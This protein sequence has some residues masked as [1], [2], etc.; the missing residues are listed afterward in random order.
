LVL[1]STRSNAQFSIVG[2][3]ELRAALGPDLDYYSEFMDLSM[4][5]EAVSRAFHEFLR[6]KYETI[7]FDLIIALQDRAIDFVRARRDT[8]FRET[9]L[10]FL[11][12]NSAVGRLENET[13]VVHERNFDAT[14]AFIRQ[15]Q[16][17]VQH[18]FVVTGA[19]EVDREY[20]EALRRQLQASGDGLNIVYL[21]GL[22]AAELEDRLSRLPERSAV[23]YVFV[24]EDAAGQK[25]HPLTYA[26]TVSAMA[27]APTYSW[28]DS[29]IDHGIVGGSL[30]RQRLAVQR[31]GQLAARVLRGEPIDTIPV[32]ALSLNAN[33]ADWRQLRRWRID[34]SRV[35]AGSLIRFRNPT[36][37]DQY[38]AYILA[39]L[40]LLVAETALIAGL[41]IHRQRRRRV[42]EV[43]RGVNSE[44]R[45]SHERNR[46]LGA[47]LLKAQET[48]RAQIA[49]E[50]HDDI[51]QRMLLL[52]I[53]LDS[54]SRATAPQAPAREALRL[55][56][57]LA[58]SLHELSHRLYPA[59][60]RLIGLVSALDHLCA[61][62]S[63]A[64]ATVSFVHR[65]VPP[66]L[67]PE[68]MLCVFRVV[69]EALHN[70]FKYS[71]A[72]DL[73]V[74]LSGGSSGLT[75]VVTDDGAGFDV[76]EAW[77]KGV[78][79][80]SMVERLEAIGGTLQIRSNH[81]GG[82]SLTASIP[83]SSLAGPRADEL[84]ATPSSAGPPRTAAS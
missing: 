81:G 30:Y 46:A 10:V 8:L 55:T 7:R 39:A 83:P 48:E 75:V 53:E 67:P 44:L 80:G 23:Y 73:S 32:A 35:P 31:V 41:L 2:E 5:P 3:Q 22:A 17:D 16:P 13:G 63:H 50:L 57:D 1:Y 64:G 26:D 70:A 6:L 36:V 61:E 65:D 40:T 43:L 19:G 21:S 58:T 45:R 42:E 76:N 49:Q 82:S 71:G 77:G 60:L 47:R 11:T 68:V 72:K 69:Q 52:T 78:G 14:V 28:V 54:L 84:P 27:N 59:K 74:R 33:E 18:V 9:P 12:N 34:E 51:C 66:T 4:L 56:Q 25:F 15:L 62:L 24:S 29:T 37:W 20:E 79:L 38:G